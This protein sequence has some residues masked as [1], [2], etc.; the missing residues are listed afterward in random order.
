MTVQSGS[1]Q[2][3]Q[4]IGRREDLIDLITT[5]SPT[6][7]PVLSMSGSTRA[8]NTYHEWQTDALKSP[9]AVARIEGDDANYK[10]ITPTTRLGNYTQIIDNA[11]V[12]TDTQEAVGGAGRS[13][14]IEY[15]TTKA[16]KELANDIEYALVVNTASAVGA[17]GTARTLKGVQG[18]IA[19]NV[20]T[21]TGSLTASLVDTQL[22]AAWLAGGKPDVIICGGTQKMAFTNTTNFPGITKNVQASI[23]EYKNYVD[24]YQGGIGGSLKIVPSTIM[25]TAL[26][27]HVYIMEMSKWRKAWLRPIKRTELAK[28]GDG[29][30]FQI[31]AELTLECLQEKANGAVKLS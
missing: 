18:W 12:V 24:I 8:T 30:K 25:G 2:T 6:D 10:T 16:M 15:Q 9:T 20:G 4:A 7:T 28:T 5:I 19:T 22:K 1:F 23:G 3:Y 26:D 17:S 11:F 31:V 21:A 27:G 14:E 29:R 13:S